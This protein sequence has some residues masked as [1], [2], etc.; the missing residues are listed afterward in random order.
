MYP[1]RPI[2]NRGKAQETFSERAADRLGKNVLSYFLT[3][4]DPVVEVA[5]QT[6]IQRLRKW[7]GEWISH[8]HTINKTQG[9]ECWAELNFQRDLPFCLFFSDLDTVIQ[10]TGG[11]IQCCKCSQRAN[12]YITLW[13]KVQGIFVDIFLS[14]SMPWFAWEVFEE[15]RR[16]W[17]KKERHVV[18]TVF[19]IDF[20]YSC[21]MFRDALP[22]KRL[23]CF[24]YFALKIALT[25]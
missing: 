3:S 7:C 16:R 2:L 10:N 20:I 8:H 1:T 18:E 25:R 17:G 24:C 15:M 9:N 6:S 19:R 21:N 23:V 4:R 13:I 11:L 5:E 12:L 22:G 14:F